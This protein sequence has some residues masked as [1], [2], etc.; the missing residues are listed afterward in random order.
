MSFSYPFIIIINILSKDLMKIKMKMNIL[1]N[2]DIEEY[3][4]LNK[5]DKKNLI[6]T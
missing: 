1:F 2:I 6:D 3:N 5:I 4:L